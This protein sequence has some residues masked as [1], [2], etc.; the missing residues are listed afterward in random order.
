MDVKL[1]CAGKHFLR[2]ADG[3]AGPQ[4]KADTQ[5]TQVREQYRVA[6]VRA[7]Q[8][9]LVVKDDE[10]AVRRSLRPAV[11]GYGL[12]PPRYRNQERLRGDGCVPPP[13]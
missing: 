7:P 4:E 5:Q 12:T 11:H 13:L 1:V 8:V 3:R 9:C 6:P 10:G 2:P